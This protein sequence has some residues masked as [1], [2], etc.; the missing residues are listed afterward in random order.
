MS[1]SSDRDEDATLVQAVQEN[2]QQMSVQLGQPQDAD[3]IQHLYQTAQA[4]LS[5]LSPDPL[6]LAR[7]AGVL[8]VYQLSDTDPSEEKWFKAALQ[9]CSDGEA[10]E[11]LVDSLSRP[12]SL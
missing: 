10:I 2:L 11:E 4:L 1:Y 6:T 9:T 8:L 3:A 12:D 5:H 7:V